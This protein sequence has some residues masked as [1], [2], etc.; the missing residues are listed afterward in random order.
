MLV[1]RSLLF[2]IA[3]YLNLAFWLVCAMVTMVLP[4][5]FLLGVALNWASS[6]LW[7]MRVIVGTRCEI[8]GIE[9]IP[10]GGIIMA[11]KHQ[12]AWETFALITVFVTRRIDPVGQKTASK[13]A[14]EESYAVSS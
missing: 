1:L 10:P 12:S 4:K 7:L 13:R 11:A 6:S 14:E 3:F 2:N 8:S 5:R 9:N